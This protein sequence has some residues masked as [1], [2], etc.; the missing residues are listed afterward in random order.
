MFTSNAGN[1][2]L[3]PGPERF[4]MLKSGSVT[5]HAGNMGLTPGPERFHMLRS[6]SVTSNSGN[7]GLTPGPERFHMLRSYS[8]CVPQ[9]LSLTECY[10]LKPVPMLHEKLP[11]REAHIQQQRVTPTRHN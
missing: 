2:G 6:G 11:Q 1:M 8:A 4:H 5:S 7:M 10:K 9:P 3:I